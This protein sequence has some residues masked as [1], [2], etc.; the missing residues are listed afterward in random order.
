[1]T[2]EGGELKHVKFVMLKENTDTQVNSQSWLLWITCIRHIAVPHQQ[3]LDYISVPCKRN[4]VACSNLH[5][6]VICWAHIVC[7]DTSML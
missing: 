7:R 1:M 6:S 3:W 5:N 2:W 4:R